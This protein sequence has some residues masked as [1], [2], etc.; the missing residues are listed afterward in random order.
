MSNELLV[1][2]YLENGSYAET[3]TTKELIATFQSEELYML[4]VPA[5]EAYAK[6]NNLILTESVDDEY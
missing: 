3:T 5:L 1:K 2:V 6:E 4:A